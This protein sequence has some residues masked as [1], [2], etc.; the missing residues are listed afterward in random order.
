MVFCIGSDEATDTTN[1][2]HHSLSIRWVD[3]R[4][5]IHEDFIGL[6]YVPDITAATLTSNIKDILV[7]CS[8]PIASN[9]M[10]RLRGV[11]EQIQVIEESAIAVNFVFISVFK[12]LL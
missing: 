10:G 4:Y 7:H 1:Q 3:E 12:S 8:L 11:A 9:M 6:V 2:E 5:E